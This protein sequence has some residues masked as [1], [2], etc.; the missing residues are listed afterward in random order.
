[1]RFVCVAAVCFGFLATGPDGLLIE[2]VQG[3]AADASG[4]QWQQTE[5]SLAL[6]H[7]GQVVWRSNHPAGEGKPYLHPVA[8]TDG[9]SLTWLKPADHPWHRAVWFTW[10][11]INGLVYWEENRQG[12]SQGRTEVLAV[13]TVADDDHCARIELDLSFHPPGKPAVLTEKRIIT[14]GLPR[15]DGSYTIDWLGTFTAPGEDAVLE[16]TPIPNQPGGVGHGGYAGLS[17]RMA[18]E[19]RGWNVINSEGLTDGKTHG[20]KARWLAVSGKTPDGKPAGI[21]IFDHPDNLRYPSRWYVAKG[22]PYVSPAVLFSEPYTLR[23]GKSL[24]LRYRILIRP[25]IMDSD[26]AQR[27]WETFAK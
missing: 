16:R 14:I 27:E 24:S 10:K 18:K 26:V 8:L 20:Q 5:D 2:P 4:Y 22:M 15:D 12:L 11:K 19:T 23:A 9:T 21:A 17:F 6:V 3:A 13:K 7:D 1:M 25:G